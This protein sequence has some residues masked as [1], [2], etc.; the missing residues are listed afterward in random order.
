MVEDAEE[1]FSQTVKGER[2]ANND[3]SSAFL[4]NGN[5]TGTGS[6]GKLTRLLPPSSTLS[7]IASHT[8]ARWTRMHF[9]GKS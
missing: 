1:W 7:S 3:H 9:Q 6:V 8:G 4:K 2:D 5:N